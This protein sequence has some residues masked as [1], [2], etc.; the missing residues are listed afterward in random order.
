MQ[1]DNSLG[2][3]CSTCPRGRSCKTSSLR[4]APTRCSRTW[5]QPLTSTRCPRLTTWFLIKA[6][7]CAAQ[8]QDTCHS[9]PCWGGRGSRL[10]TRLP[11]CCSSALWFAKMIEYARRFGGTVHLAQFLRTFGSY[12]Q[13]SSKGDRPAEEGKW[14]DTCVR[15]FLCWSVIGC[16]AFN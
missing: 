7:A 5:D 6:F 2:P 9:C 16:E 3:D 1:R 8:T 4:R 12:E 13:P 11:T 14:E 10:W 15:E